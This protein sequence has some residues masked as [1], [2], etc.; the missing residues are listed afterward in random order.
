MKSILDPSFQYTPSAETD[1]KKTFARAWR[2]LRARER[3][4]VDASAGRN[5]EPAERP[6]E[7]ANAESADAG[8]IKTFVVRESVPGMSLVTFVGSRVAT[9]SSRLNRAGRG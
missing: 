5:T 3:L 4:H 8:S 9:R 2:E 7:A 6:D 1:I